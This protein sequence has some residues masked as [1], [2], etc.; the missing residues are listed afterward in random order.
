[1]DHLQL[2]GGGDRAWTTC[3]AGAQAQP[4]PVRAVG[5]GQVHQGGHVPRDC[6]VCAVGTGTPL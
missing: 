6:S 4:V 3:S 5:A 1:M 2:P